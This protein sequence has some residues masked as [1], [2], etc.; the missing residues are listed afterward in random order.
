MIRMEKYGTWWNWC[1][2]FKTNQ[3]LSKYLL[4]LLDP[5]SNPE[6]NN[7][8]SAGASC[9]ERYLIRNS[10]LEPEAEVKTWGQQTEKQFSG[11]HR[12]QKK[13]KKQLQPRKKM[14]KRRIVISFAK[15]FAVSRFP[16]WMI[17]NAIRSGWPWQLAFQP[18]WLTLWPHSPWRTMSDHQLT[19]RFIP[20][21][22]IS[23]WFMAVPLLR[24]KV[25]PWRPLPEAEGEQLLEPRLGQRPASCCPARETPHWDPSS[26]KREP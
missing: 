25:Q 26:S 12:I 5:K 2:K 23:W 11:R 20:L 4:T 18:G 17:E 22:S 21:S 16:W 6:T 1:L 19:H 24:T 8:P 9:H 15:A 13:V 10:W 7:T 14:K 3:I